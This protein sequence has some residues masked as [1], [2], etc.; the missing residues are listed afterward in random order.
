MRS[1][2]QYLIEGEKCT[3]FFFDMEMR[4]GMS[5]TIKLIK[6]ENEEELESN[7]EILK[8]MKRYY[9][10]LFTTEGVQDGKEEML[11]HIKTK[12]GKEDKED[13]DKEIREEEIERSINKLNKKKSS[14]IDGLGSEFYI[15]FEDVLT[16]ILKEVYDEIFKKGQM[17]LR[18]GM[19]L[20]KLLYKK[21]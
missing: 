3:K 1:K 18:M 5:E 6:K 19:A 8:E 16:N 2:A 21:C 7:E 17:N 10:L 14:G 15:V 11:K 13:F 4:K 12:V 20:R 9:E